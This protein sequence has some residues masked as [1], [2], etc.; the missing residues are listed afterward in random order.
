MVSVRYLGGTTASPQTVKINPSYPGTPADHLRMAASHL[1]ATL[2]D[3]ALDEAL[4]MFCEI[5]QHYQPHTR[6]GINQ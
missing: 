3:A 5:W 1:L 2:P 4:K 6:R